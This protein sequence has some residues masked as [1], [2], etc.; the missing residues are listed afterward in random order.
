MELGPVVA[1][2]GRRRPG[3]HWK[4]ARDDDGIAWLVLD[5]PGSSAN[6]LSEE[7]LGELDAVLGQHRARSAE[8]PGAPLGQAAAASSPAPISANSRH[9]RRADRSTSA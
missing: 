9:D 4:L 1:R 6:T 5:K 7:V 2:R 3:Q 8:G